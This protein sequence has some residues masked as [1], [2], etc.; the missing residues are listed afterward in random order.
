MS[1]QLYD[2]R[3]EYE[4]LA[5]LAMEAPNLSDDPRELAQ[6]L[7]AI[8]E[9]LNPKLLSLAKVVRTLEAEAGLLEEHGRA[10]MGRASTRRVRVDHLKHWMQL[11]MEGAELERLKDPFVIVWL[12]RSPASIAVLN[13]E[14]VPAEFKRVTLKLPL[15]AVPPGLLG[16][17][18][19]C[20]IDRTAIHELIKSTGELPPGI[21]YVCDRRH[22]RIH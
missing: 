19:T 21:E 10:L 1:T 22:L 17:V 20:D 8:R 15:S 2:L 6:E 13:E 14:V 18:Q 9:E 11:Q 5:D 4:S 7:E 3:P 16:L 12:Q